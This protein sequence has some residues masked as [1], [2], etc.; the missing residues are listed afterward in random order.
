MDSTQIYIGTWNVNG[1]VL[2]KDVNLDQWISPEY[3]NRKVCLYSELVGG[4]AGGRRFRRQSAIGSRQL[5]V[6]AVRL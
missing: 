6:G 4:G 3:P 5:A 2:T 1:C